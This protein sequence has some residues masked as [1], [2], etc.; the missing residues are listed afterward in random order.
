MLYIML[1]IRILLYFHTFYMILIVDVCFVKAYRYLVNIACVWHSF[2]MGKKSIRILSTDIYIQ[3]KAKIFSL[4]LSCKGYI[5]RVNYTPTCV[6]YWLCV[7]KRGNLRLITG[8]R[9]T[10]KGR[11]EDTSTLPQIVQNCFKLVNLDLKII[12]IMYPFMRMTESIQVFVGKTI[13]YMDCTTLWFTL[14]C[15]YFCK[16]N[17][18]LQN[19]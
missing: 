2:R 18:L 13:V 1:V 16:Y 9:Q 6:R 19:T 12:F 17:A 4:E 15:K 10:P 3:L 5:S 8:L 7:Q 11:Y 14:Y